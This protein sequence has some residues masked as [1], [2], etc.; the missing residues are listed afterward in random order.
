[1]K[2]LGLFYQSQKKR[3]DKRKILRD[4][5]LWHNFNQN[6]KRFFLLSASGILQRRHRFT[7]SSFVIFSVLWIMTILIETYFI[8]TVW[9]SIQY[10]G[11]WNRCTCKWPISVETRLRAITINILLKWER[12]P[13]LVCVT[14]WRK[15]LSTCIHLLR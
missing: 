7:E 9:W 6:L 11:E 10:G 8:M 5:R 14:T 12:V 15:Q 13:L 4:I 3:R 1:M 2:F